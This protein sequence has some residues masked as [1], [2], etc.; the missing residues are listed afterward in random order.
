[1]TPSEQA[2]ARLAAAMAAA[3]ARTDVLSAGLTIAAAAALLFGIGWMPASLVT[4]TL[5]LIGRYFGFRIA[6]DRRLFDDLAEKRTV[7]ADLDAALRAAT[8]GKAGAA[9]RSIAERCRGIRRL[10]A[11]H[12]L[13]TAAQ[14]VATGMVIV[15]R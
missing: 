8:G 4:M 11:F 2:E 13:V 14:V 9:T 15:V 6:I 7:P 5:G 10:L 3:A 12:A 1:M